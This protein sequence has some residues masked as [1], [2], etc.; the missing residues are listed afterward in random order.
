MIFICRRVI[1]GDEFLSLTSDELI[2][3]ISSNN[4][5]VPYEE[6]VSS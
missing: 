5:D 6:R 1:Q 3:L 4:L 2:R